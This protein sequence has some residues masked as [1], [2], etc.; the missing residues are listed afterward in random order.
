[1]DCFVV[2][3]LAMTAEG[4]GWMVMMSWR[5]SGDAVGVGGGKGAALRLR[6]AG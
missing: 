5:E 1:M 3:L 6:A 2:G 4:Q